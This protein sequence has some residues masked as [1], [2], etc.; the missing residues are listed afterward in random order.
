VRIAVVG[1]TRIGCL[2]VDRLRTAGHDVV[3]M[4]SS[5]GVDPVARTGFAEVL[6]GV[7]VVVDAV[8]PRTTD[9][10]PARWFLETATRNLLAAGRS[11]GVHHYVLLSVVG[12]DQVDRGYFRAKNAQ[13]ARVRRSGLP[14]TI[15]RS[16]QVHELV[17]DVV[18]AATEGRSVRLAAVPIQPV[19]SED[20][21]AVLADRATGSPLQGC[22]EVAGPE[23]VALEEL[24]RRWLQAGCDD[25]VVVSSPTATYLGVELVA[26]DRSLL[27]RLVL[28]ERTFDAWLAERHCLAA[29]A[30]PAELAS[31]AERTIAS[32]SVEARA[33]PA[34]SSGVT[35]TGH[36]A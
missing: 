28:G 21:A 11:A 17:P 2:L 30:Q 31:S 34:P 15:V 24:A 32:P 29:E 18:E 4:S 7:T 9:A 35:S 13:E 27:P 14:F 8:E 1:E 23:E 33:A 25:R 26:G 22:L 20:L 5:T 12:V 19:A 10:G 36:V 16:T 6:R 3:T